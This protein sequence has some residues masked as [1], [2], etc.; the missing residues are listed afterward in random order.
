M[1]C[2]QQAQVRTDVVEQLLWKHAVLSAAEVDG[3]TP[4]YIAP[5]QGH[6]EVIRFL[7]DAGAEKNQAM[8]DGATP[9]YLASQCS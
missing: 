8:T 4:L 7:C 9:L 1:N 2:V 6:L 3:H 5:H